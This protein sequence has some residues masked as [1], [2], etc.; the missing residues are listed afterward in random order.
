MLNK[1]FRKD[2]DRIMSPRQLINGLLD[3]NLYD[4]LAWAT[5]YVKR[6]GLTCIECI[7][8]RSDLSGK[9]PDCEK[10]GL[11]VSRLLKKYFNSN[12]INLDKGEINE[13]V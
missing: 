11:P 9:P 8:T 3:S 2:D 4:C 7:Q 10:C 13:K 5:W 6:G 12:I 1:K